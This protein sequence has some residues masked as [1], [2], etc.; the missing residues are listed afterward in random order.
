MKGRIA[1][2]GCGAQKLD[3]AAEA[4]SMYVG[5]YFRSCYAAADAIAPGQVWILSALYGLLRPW[6]LIRPY[7]LTIGQLGAVTAGTVSLQ[8]ARAGILDVDVIALCGSRYADIA[9][10]VWPGRVETPLQGL[11]LGAQRALCNQLRDRALSTRR[12][13]PLAGIAAQGHGLD[14]DS[15]NI[16][17]ATRTEGAAK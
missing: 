17:N 14:L 4:A 16:V 15:S 1:L 3:H 9:R 5:P 11:G 8:A 6:T 7:D 12:P 2:V 13:G 10:A